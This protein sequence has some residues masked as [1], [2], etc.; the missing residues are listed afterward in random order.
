MIGHQKYLC[1]T[2]YILQVV[3][4]FAVRSVLDNLAKMPTAGAMTLMFI[5]IIIYAIILLVTCFKRQVGRMK[6]RSKR[7]PH[8]PG[9]EAKKV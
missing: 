8:V 3:V 1:C 2:E 5:A 6:D 4:Q 7:D 9:S